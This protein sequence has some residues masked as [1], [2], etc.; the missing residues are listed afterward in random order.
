MFG[1]H[2]AFPV[3]VSGFIDP[4]R[5]GV[6]FLLL[7]SSWRP[8]SEVR[9]CDLKTVRAWSLRGANRSVHHTLLC[10]DSARQPLRGRGLSLQRWL[11]WLC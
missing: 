5:S 9:G 2:L 4:G 1:K 6:V 10:L 8:G 11:E 3:T 7:L